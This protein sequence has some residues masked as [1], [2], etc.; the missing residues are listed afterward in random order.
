[1]KASSWWRPPSVSGVYS[2]LA[3]PWQDVPERPLDSYDSRDNADLPEA[4][5]YRDMSQFSPPVD[6]ASPRVSDPLAWL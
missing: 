3:H 6:A 4:F 5:H 1:M 2:S